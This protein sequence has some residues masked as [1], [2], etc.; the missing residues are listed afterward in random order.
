MKKDTEEYTEE[1]YA[2]LVEKYNMSARA[3]FMVLGLA[4]YVADHTY[5]TSSYEISKAPKSKAVW[6]VACEIA[7]TIYRKEK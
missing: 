3:Y 5:C 4:L 7:K 2:S 1:G 6:A